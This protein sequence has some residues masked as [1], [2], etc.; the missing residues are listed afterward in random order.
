MD[1]AQ[2]DRCFEQARDLAFGLNSLVA[3][4]QGED[5]EREILTLLRTLAETCS[6][7]L[8]RM[9]ARVHWKQ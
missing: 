5:S 3:S 4:D 1:K 9:R 7:T 2:L 8:A 6:L